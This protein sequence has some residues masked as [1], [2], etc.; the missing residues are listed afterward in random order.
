M[1]IEDWEYNGYIYPYCLL[2]EN[3]IKNKL[4]KWKHAFENVALSDVYFRYDVLD[5]YFEYHMSIDAG[6]LAC[7]IDNKIFS[8]RFACLEE[9]L[10]NGILSLPAVATIEQFV[11]NYVDNYPFQYPYAFHDI[12]EELEKKVKAVYV[13]QRQWRKSISDPEYKMC[14]DRLKRE[15]K[16]MY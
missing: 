11:Q 15:F 13:I 3:T 7:A 10:I 9:G 14:R 1:P 16:E 6:C 4:L 5:I 12:E 2:L 8:T